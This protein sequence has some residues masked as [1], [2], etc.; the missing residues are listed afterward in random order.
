MQ[1]HPAR[2][3]SRRRRRLLPL[4]AHRRIPRSPPH[5]LPSQSPYRYPLL[6]YLGGGIG[7]GGGSTWMS[8]TA[9]RKESKRD[10]VVRWPT[11]GR[12]RP[13]R[14]R[15]WRSFSIRRGDVLQSVPPSP[16]PASPST[17]LLS[18]K[19]GGPRLSRA[20]QQ[21]GGQIRHSHILSR[22][23]APGEV[24]RGGGHRCRVSGDWCGSRRFDSVV[25]EALTM[26]G[27]SA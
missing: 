16:P 20:S 1:R 12:R 9:H 15:P 27:A 18:L 7:D 26:V 6:R 5:L 3:R 23:V 13:W 24:D 25:E 10:D 17:H 2:S 19:R 14:S 21:A 8:P 11:R 4:L 22:W